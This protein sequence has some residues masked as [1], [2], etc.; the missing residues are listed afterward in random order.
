MTYSD[1][2][3]GT[4]YITVKFIKDSSTHNNN[5]SV[6]LRLREPTLSTNSL[7]QI[8]GGDR[9]FV[10]SNIKSGV[11][12][13]GVTG[14]YGGSGGGSGS[15]LSTCTLNTGSYPTSGAIFYTDANGT[16][17]YMD[18]NP[19]TGNITIVCGKIYVVGSVEVGLMDD[20]G[21]G[22][23]MSLGSDSTMY[24]IDVPASVY[25]NRVVDFRYSFS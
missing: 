6:R 4:H 19:G 14:T 15:G 25:A 16:T 9:E 7:T 12:I 18:I 22:T 11:N 24:C 23:E 13:Y 20:T 2:S 1:V 5:D 17:Q 10:A 21:P 8:V 3:A